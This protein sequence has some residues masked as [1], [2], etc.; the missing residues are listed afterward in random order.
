VHAGLQF[1]R[2]ARSGCNFVNCL[3]GESVAG[4]LSLR[5]QQLDVRV[6]TKTKDNVFV[7]IVV[8]VQYQVRRI[9][10]FLCCV[11]LDLLPIRVLTLHWQLCV[12]SQVQENALFDAFYRLTNS[13]N[14]I[15]SYVFDVVQHTSHTLVRM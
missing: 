9:V 8:S 14:Q 13:S 15:T 12:R 5:V 6:D 2:I 4:K 7:R 11:K 10:I 3:I 1:Q